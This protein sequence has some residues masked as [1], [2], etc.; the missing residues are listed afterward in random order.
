LAGVTDRY[1]ADACA[2]IVFFADASISETVRELMSNADV[3]VS[4]IT[5]WEISRKVALGKLPSDW[6]QGGLVGLLQR[7]GFRPLPLSWSE[8]A[9]ANDLPPIHKDPMDRMLIAQAMRH[10]LAIITND[11]LFDGYGV[12]TVW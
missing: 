5:V 1:L 10:D 7:Q 11:R 3:A 12:R 9:M 6:G 8:A 4:A 2:L